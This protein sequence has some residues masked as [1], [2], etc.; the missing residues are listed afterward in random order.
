MGAMANLAIGDAA[1]DFALVID[2]RGKIT[3]VFAPVKVDGHSDAVLEAVAGAGAKTK[4]K[5]TR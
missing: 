2:P 5:T 4:A 3:R 1:P